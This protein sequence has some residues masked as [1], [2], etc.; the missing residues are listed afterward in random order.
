MQHLIRYSAGLAITLLAITRPVTAAALPSAA[1]MW[2]IIQQQ[3]R[4]IEAL[5]A[6]QKANSEKVDATAEAIDT[7]VTSTQ[8]T[9]RN[10]SAGGSTWTDNTRIG[11]YGEL[12]Y[13]NLDSGKQIDLHR[14]VMFL[15]HQFN[16]RLR[17]FSELEVEHVI[18]SSDT[19]DKGEVE[20]EQAYL[21]YDLTPDQHAKAGLFLV[22]V[23]I[24]NETHEPPTF[25][26]VERNPVETQII[27]STW[28]VGGAGLSGEIMPGWSYDLAVHEG[29]K[30]AAGDTFAV[31]KGRQEG[32]HADANDLA[33]TAR[34]RWTGIPG[35]EL[36]ATIQYQQDVTQG[37]DPAA[38]DAWLYEAHASIQRGPF[39]LR[40]LYARWNLDGRGP[41]AVGADIQE[42]F[43]IEPSYKI[44]PG[45]GVFAR[46]NDWDNQAGSRGHNTG[47]TQ[48]NTGL[49]FWPHPDVVLK[50]D[51]QIQDN[52]SA[53]NDN[54]Y[55]L[56]IGYQF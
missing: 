55:N 25:Y 33:S 44:T 43:Y 11:S 19:G 7:G 28:F 22:P 20:V 12:H 40:A 31:R 48:I 3:Q 1:E 51:V 27:P 38:G 29:L 45:W 18:A 23:G 41:K 10:A 21:E 50:A 49:N 36:A 8:A 17:M 35:V 34:L 56:G 15:G 13:N 53:K 54:G 47:K 6:G 37:N 2:K 24:L 52:N 16:D 9:S 4:E 42:G 26:G 32:S 14:F 46:Y 39:G 30:T 5:K